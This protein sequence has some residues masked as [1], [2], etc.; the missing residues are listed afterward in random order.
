MFRSIKWIADRT[1]A[2]VGLAALSPLLALVSLLIRVMLGR[3]ILFRQ[4]RPGLHGR[5]FRLYKFRTMRD[6]V[7]PDGRLL[8]DEERMTPLGGVLRSLSIDELPQ[9]LNVLKGEMSIVGP[10]PLLVE[11]LSL[12]NAEQARR[13]NVRPGITGL[14]QVSGRNNLPWD[15]RLALDTWYADHWSLKLDI[16]ILVQTVACVLKRRGISEKGHATMTPF[17]GSAT[18]PQET[19]RAGA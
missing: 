9:L 15:E 5:L 1:T 6:A 4:T 8:P 17:T 19:P 12:Y 2:L 7:G 11:Y 14:A 16:R 18:A 10:R 3:P 13:H